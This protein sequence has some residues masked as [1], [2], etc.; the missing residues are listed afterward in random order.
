MFQIREEE[1]R[2]IHIYAIHNFFLNNNPNT[3]NFRLICL[4][5]KTTNVPRKQNLSQSEVRFSVLITK[6]KKFCSFFPFLLFI[7]VVNLSGNHLDLLSKTNLLV[8]LQSISSQ[9]NQLS[10]LPNKLLIVNS[11]TIGNYTSWRQQQMLQCSIVLKHNEEIWVKS[12][13]LSLLLGVRSFLCVF[14]TIIFR[15]RQLFIDKFSEGFKW[16]FGLQRH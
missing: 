14:Y 10:S 16:M 15:L 6:V 3:L 11:Q 1:D 2:W 13:Q 8:A 4:A 5:H 7:S 9:G 12:A